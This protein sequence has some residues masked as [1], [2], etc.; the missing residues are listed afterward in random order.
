MGLTACTSKSAHPQS[1]SSDV[2]HVST[3]QANGAKVTV[4]VSDGCPATLDSAT[5]VATSPASQADK[6]LPAGVSPRDGLICEYAIASSGRH[7]PRLTRRIPLT[8]PAAT[9]L[10]AAIS[11]ISLKPAS[12]TFSCPAQYFGT[13][14]VIAFDYPSDKTVD[15][16]YETSGCRTLDNGDVL[17]FQGGN[18]SFYNGFETSFDSLTTSHP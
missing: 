6:L 1:G 5:D 8:R 16:W 2:G 17:A 4:S 18:P 3:G 11:T 7:V 10:A 13:D 15:L 14:T 9:K 12:G